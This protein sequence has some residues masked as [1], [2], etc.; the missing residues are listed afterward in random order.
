MPRRFL[1]GRASLPSSGIALA[2]TYSAAVVPTLAVALA[3]APLPAGCSSP[4]DSGPLPATNGAGGRATGA[5]GG[6]VNSG[7]SGGTN[8][9]TAAGGTTGAGAGGSS[10]DAGAPTGSGLRQGRD[11]LPG[12]RLSRA[13][14]PDRQRLRMGAATHLSR[15]DL[16]PG[17]QHRPL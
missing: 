12:L 2:R 14:Q 1:G 5:G 7:G 11:L 16:G 4:A 6:A 13:H 3:L 15:G 9:T 10:A 8:G 17:G